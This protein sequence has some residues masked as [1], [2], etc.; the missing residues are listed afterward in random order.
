MGLPL[1]T[2]AARPKSKL[3]HES[4]FALSLSLFRPSPTLILYPL[5]RY[6]TLPCLSSSLASW[7]VRTIA[8]AYSL[9]PVS[10]PEIY[11]SDPLT[12]PLPLSR[13]RSS[14]LSL[15]IPRGDLPTARS[16][17]NETP[18][19]RLRLNSRPE[20]ARSASLFRADVPR[21]SMISRLSTY[22]FSSLHPTPVFRLLSSRFPHPD[23]PTSDYRRD[24]SPLTLK[25]D[26]IKKDR[27][28][29]HICAE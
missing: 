11:P 28:S 5:A 24:R 18:F 3:Y 9:C 27:M 14:Y 25:N 2:T 23:L 15:R 20:E 12:P 6:A 19:P 13:S 21:A 22:L 8:T 17:N 10:I 7:Y 26:S 4:R 16:L 29:Y 1:D